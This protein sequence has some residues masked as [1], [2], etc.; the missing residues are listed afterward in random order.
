MIYGYARCSTDETKQ[1]ID[2]QVRELKSAG[3]EKVFFEYEH[4]DS[5]TKQQLSLFFDVAKEGDTLITTE[6][7]RL[8][9]ST[10]QLCEI[11]EIIRTKKLM[12]VIIGSMT[13]DC[14]GGD[15]DPMTNAFLQISGVFAELERAM[16]VARIKSGLKHAQSQGTK[17]GRPT[18]TIEKI[19][20]KFFR[21]YPTYK[22][23]N[24]KKIDFARVCKISRPTLDAYIKKVETKENHDLLK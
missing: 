24:I 9:R 15:I 11:I 2:R 6:V 4:G 17:I 23:G 8:S 22:A 21:Y 14:R 10:K 7:T 12:L 13:V 19:P 18:L 3:A 5:S 1:D 20:P 16:T